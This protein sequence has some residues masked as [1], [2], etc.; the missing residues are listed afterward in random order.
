MSPFPGEGWQPVKQHPYLSIQKTWTKRAEQTVNWE[1]MDK[2]LDEEKSGK[3]GLGISPRLSH[4]Q[5]KSNPLSLLT[6]R[7]SLGEDT[8]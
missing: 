5:Y 4:L 7:E 2:L 8:L 3:T 6:L 1:S